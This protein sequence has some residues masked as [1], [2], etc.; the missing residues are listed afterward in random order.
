MV[1]SSRTPTVIRDRGTLT[2]SIGIAQAQEGD[3]VVNLLGK[4]NSKKIWIIPGNF[5]S[6]YLRKKI[7]NN[8]RN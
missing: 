6:L 3:D 7:E 4:N 8:S 2:N 5:V 1:C